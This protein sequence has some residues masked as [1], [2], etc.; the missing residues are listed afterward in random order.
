[1]AT[2]KRKS[3]ASRRTDNKRAKHGPGMEKYKDVQHQHNKSQTNCK[4][5]CAW[6]QNRFDT[7][8]KLVVKRC[9]LL[10]K[11]GGFDYCC[12]HFTESKRRI[13][14][15]LK[16]PKKED[17]MKAF[18]FINIPGIPIKVVRTR[19]YTEKIHFANEPKCLRKKKTG[20]LKVYMNIGYHQQGFIKKEMLY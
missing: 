20:I 11:K 4:K 12:Y 19:F 14:D 7:D 18:E 3:D 8:G 17:I 5:C 1:M 9:E 16:Y 6:K 2:F 13:G 15:V 10:A